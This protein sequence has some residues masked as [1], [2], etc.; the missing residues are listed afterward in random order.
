MGAWTY[1]EPRLRELV[2]DRLEV[3]YEGRP[4]RASPAE[5]YAERHAAEQARIVDAAWQGAEAPTPA[6]AAK[7]A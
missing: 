6:R 7:R 2:G 4:Y 5:G 3:R 1:M